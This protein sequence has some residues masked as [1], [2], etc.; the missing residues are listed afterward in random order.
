MRVETAQLSDGARI[1]LIIVDGQ[2]LCAGPI[3]E[4][5]CLVY[6]VLKEIPTA[7]GYAT[8]TLYFE[9]VK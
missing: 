3:P 1:K 2:R 6:C 9:V 8:E 4:D 5:G 7:A